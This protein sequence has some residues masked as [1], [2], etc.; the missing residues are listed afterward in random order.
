VAADY[1]LYRN[2][3]LFVPDPRRRSVP[4]GSQRYIVRNHPRITLPNVAYWPETEVTRRP[5]FGRDR[6]KTGHNSDIAEVKR[7]T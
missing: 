4:E 3:T 5:R 2:W 6:V 1:A 7:L